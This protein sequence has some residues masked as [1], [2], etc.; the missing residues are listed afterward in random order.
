MNFHAAMNIFFPS[1]SP[2][3]IVPQGME[4]F[5]LPLTREIHHWVEVHHMTFSKYGLAHLRIFL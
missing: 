1:R 2:G 3:I 4:E 5:A